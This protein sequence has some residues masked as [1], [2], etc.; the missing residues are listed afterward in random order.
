MAQLQAQ[1][2]NALT[3]H[4][5]KRAKIVTRTADTTGLPRVSQEELSKFEFYKKGSFAWEFRTSRPGKEFLALNLPEGMGVVYFYLSS[6]PVLFFCT[7]YRHILA[8][9]LQHIYDT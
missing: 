3:Y 5:A 9:N 1:S 6:T 2:R 4:Q 8:G 7:N